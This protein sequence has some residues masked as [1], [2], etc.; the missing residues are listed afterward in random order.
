MK[1][2]RH[3]WNKFLNAVAGRSVYFGALLGILP[4]LLI[5]YGGYTMLVEPAR[6][7]NQ[8]KVKAVETLEAEVERGKAVEQSEKE[9]KQEFTKVVELFYESLP[10]LPKETELSSVLLSVQESARRYNVT[11]TGLN[12][13]RDAQKTANADK[14]YEREM[15]AVVVGSFDDCMRFFLDVSRM[16]RILIIRDFTVSPANSPPVCPVLC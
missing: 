1:N 4:A 3:S 14:L 2:L 16:T 12:A 9:F 15:P 11:L 8:E 7:V 5:I 6:A 13:V 10:L